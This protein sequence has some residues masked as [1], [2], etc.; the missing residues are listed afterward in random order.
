MKVVIAGGGTAGHVFPALALAD[1]LRRDAGATVLFVGSPDGQEATLVP[2]AGYEFHAVRA[3]KMVR[4]LS[5]E[6]ARAPFVALRSVRACRPLVKDAD[7][8]VGLGGYVSAPAVLAVRRPGTKIVLMEQNAVPGL[9]NRLLAHRAD[10]VGVA[11]ED[12]RA[13]FR[14]RVPVRVT[15]NPVRDTILSVAEHRSDVAASA[16]PALGL[17]PDRRTVAVFGGSLGALH[18]DRAIAGVIPLLR[19]RADLQLFVASGPAHLDVVTTAANDAGD[20]LVRVVPFLEQMELALAVADLAV[21]RSGAGH[22]AELTVCGVPAI[23]VP[24]PHATEN[25]QEANAREVVRAGAA[26]M[27]L[28]DELSPERLADRIVSLLDN[29]D[30]RRAMSEAARA[31]ARPDAADR[32]AALV[33]E[34]AA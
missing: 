26:D 10:A 19:N 32:L 5:V 11:F 8:V 7:V 6:T 29:E 25:H 34:V 2:S 27:L 23:L 13:R 17:R 33:T 9:V 4:S 24:Y 16:W 18:L 30:R 21:A 14:A 20:L 12:A 1:R 15:G 31:W 3:Q 28:D 22:I